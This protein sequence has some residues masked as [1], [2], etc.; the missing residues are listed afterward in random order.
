MG[1]V[2]AN[3][4]E[5][6]Y[7]NVVMEDQPADMF[8]SVP[9]DMT[10][11]ERQELAA[12]EA[13]GNTITPYVLPPPAGDRSNYDAM[14]DRRMNAALAEGDTDSAFQILLKRQE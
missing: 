14:L 12:W 2:S 4:T 9:D 11:R 8:I 5:G 10:I 1:I 6:G 3:Y 13:E 7:I